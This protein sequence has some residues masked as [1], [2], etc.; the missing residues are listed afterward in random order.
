MDNHVGR[1]SK[2]KMG[3]RERKREGSFLMTILETLSRCNK[4][5]LRVTIALWSWGKKVGRRSYRAEKAGRY[6]RSG[7]GGGINSW[8]TRLDQGQLKEIGRGVRNRK[9]GNLRSYKGKKGGTGRIRRDE[10]KGEKGGV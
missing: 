8:Y 2:R 6:F 1:G 10:G 4:R 5:G 7:R 9:V 3:Q